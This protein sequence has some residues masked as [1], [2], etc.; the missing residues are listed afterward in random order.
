DPGALAAADQLLFMPDLFHY[1][2]SGER[3]VEATNASTSQ[4]VDCH[5][6]D[7][8]YDI[9]AQLGIPTNILGPISPPGTQIG[10]LRAKLVEETGLAPTLRVVA[11]ATHDTASAVAAVPAENGT[12]WCFLS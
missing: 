5:T 2:L 12:R 10:N 7:W 1:W 4:M 3:V 9:V 8:A 6:G 11:P